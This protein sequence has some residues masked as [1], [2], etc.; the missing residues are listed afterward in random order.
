M[1]PK[2]KA[3]AIQQS[4]ID[5]LGK[6]FIEDDELGKLSPLTRWAIGMDPSH[7]D[8]SIFFPVCDVDS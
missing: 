8:V 1:L 6:M 2:A 3:L 4:A 7:F 5:K